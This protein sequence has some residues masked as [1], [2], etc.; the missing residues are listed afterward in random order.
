MSNTP[1]QRQ[2]LRVQ[3]FDEMQNP[4]RPKRP[5][6]IKSF[7]RDLDD[8]DRLSLSLAVR[9]FLSEFEKLAASMMNRVPDDIRFIARKINTQPAVAG[10][11]L[12]TCLTHGFIVR[13][14][15]DL[16]T[17]RNND[18]YQKTDTRPIPPSNS[19]SQ[20]KSSSQ[21][22]SSTSIRRVSSAS[23]VRERR[24]QAIDEL[25]VPF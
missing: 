1:D 20:S 17:S 14:A 9:G 25:E 12:N 2:F 3:N 5:T 16:N 11:A 24:W 13:F 18:L 19:N 7:V 23:P 10:K 4:K 8:P 15:E 22:D 21:E 6:W